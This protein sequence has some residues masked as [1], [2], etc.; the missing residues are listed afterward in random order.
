MWWSGEQDGKWQGLQD[1]NPVVSAGWA[2]CG[3]GSAL[4]PAPATHRGARAVLPPLWDLRL[5]GVVGAADHGAGGGKPTAP[6]ARSAAARLPAGQTLLLQLRLPRAGWAAFGVQ[7]C[8]RWAT[9]RKEGTLRAGVAWKI[10]SLLCVL[11]GTLEFFASAT[12]SA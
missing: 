12:I 1:A 5:V 4:S 9:W 2:T 7:G 3:R 8:G 11:F 6:T 10:Q